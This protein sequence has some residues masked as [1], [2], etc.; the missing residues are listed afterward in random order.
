MNYEQLEVFQLAYD[1][2]LKVHQAS[3]AFPKPEQYSGLA[4]QLRRSSKSICANVAEGLSKRS[5]NA[6][7]IR[8]LSMAL[9]SCEETRVWLKFAVD[10]GY[11]SIETSQSWRE[12]YA[13]VSR[14][15]YGLMQRRK[16][17]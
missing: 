1:L 2:A 15:V 6:D 3:Q 11:L 13:R 16:A 10:L 12:Q 5:S 7:E 14:M 9:G 4:D 17:A 8:F